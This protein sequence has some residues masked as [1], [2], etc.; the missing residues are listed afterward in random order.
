MEIK[1]VRYYICEHQIGENNAGPK[2]R[3]DVEKILKSE[4]FKPIDLNVTIN[5]KYNHKENFFDKIFNKIKIEKAWKPISRQVG[6]NDIIFIQLPFLGRLFTPSKIIKWIKKRGTKIIV[7]VHDLDSFRYTADTPIKKIKRYVIKEEDI[8]T[9][10][11]ADQ[12]IVH[13]ENMRKQLKFM[14][15]DTSNMI[16]LNIFDYLI[17]NFDQYYDP[18]KIDCNKPIIVAS[19]LSKIKAGYA[20]DLPKD[21]EFNLYGPGYQ[22]GDHQKQ[23]VHYFGSFPPDELPFILEGSYGLVWDGS[24]IDKCEGPNGNY[25]KINNPHKTSLYL[26]CGIPVIVWDKAAVARFVKKNNCGITIDSLRNL[27]N[28][29]NLITPEEYKKLKKAAVEVGK[30]LRNSYYTKKALNLALTELNNECNN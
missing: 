15:F 12:I 13:N 28:T 22:G 2:A 6:K 8:K 7:L 3:E 18:Q 25:L 30:R 16:D 21:C 9:L 24:S 14:G 17:P 29:L 1:K 19:S 23:N 5:G 27:N 10:R 20:Y 26:A 4:G 11:F